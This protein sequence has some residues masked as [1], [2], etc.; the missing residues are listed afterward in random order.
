MQQSTYGNVNTYN[1][2]QASSRSISKLPD[3]QLITN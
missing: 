2:K 1:V 3:H